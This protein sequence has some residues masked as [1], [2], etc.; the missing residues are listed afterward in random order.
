[1]S[2]IDPT[3]SRKLTSSGRRLPGTWTSIKEMENDRSFVASTMMKGTNYGMDLS[4]M[5]K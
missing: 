4:G 2:R 3:G 1:M 5:R